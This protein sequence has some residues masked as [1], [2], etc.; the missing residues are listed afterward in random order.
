MGGGV[1]RGVEHAVSGGSCV[2]WMFWRMIILCLIVFLCFSL[3]EQRTNIIQITL[4]SVCLVCQGMI[5]FFVF[6]PV[7]VPER[8]ILMIITGNKNAN[9]LGFHLYGKDYRTIKLFWRKTNMDVLRAAVPVRVKKLLLLL[10]LTLFDSYG[11]RNS[12]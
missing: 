1:G 8:K 4:Y 7:H 9:W 5:L 3:F 10:T 11:Y 2:P 6:T 12:K